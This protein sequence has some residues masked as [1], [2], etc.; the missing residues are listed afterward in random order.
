MGVGGGVGD[1]ITDERGASTH[2]FGMQ[3][4]QCSVFFIRLLKAWYFLY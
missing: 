4:V 2:T 1:K 3:E